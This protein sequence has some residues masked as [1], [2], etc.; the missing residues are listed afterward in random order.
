MENTKS[1]LDELLEQYEKIT[2]QPIDETPSEM[3]ESD[4]A[5]WNYLCGDGDIRH[6]YDYYDLLEE[7]K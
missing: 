7:E 5:L 2:D 4:H 1:I 6:L 3:K